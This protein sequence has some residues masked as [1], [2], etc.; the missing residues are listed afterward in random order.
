MRRSERRDI[1]EGSLLWAAA[2]AAALFAAGFR[3]RRFSTASAVQ[4]SPL[5]EQDRGRLA[6]AP[7]KIPTRGWKDILLRAFHNISEHR[8]M[9]L[10]AGVTFY[11]LLAL[12][13]AIAALVAIYG[14]FAD[15]ATLS[16]DLDK[17]S[18]VLPGGAIEVIHDQLARLVAQ[19]GSTLGLTFIV[20]LAI[21]LWSANA[22]MKSLFGTL[23]VVYAEPEKRGLVTLN[24]Q[25][26]A[27]TVGGIVF[28]VVALGAM[29][30]L[31][32]LLGFLGLSGFTETLLR[33]GR[34]PALFV[35][36]MLAL[37][38]IYRHGP[39]REQAQW[40]WVT[41][42]SAFAALAW[43]VLSILFSWYAEN[44]GSFN[45]TYGSLGAVIGFMTWIWLSA[46]VILIGAELDAEMEHQT[47]RDTTTGPPM[48]LGARQAT[49]ADTIGAR[50]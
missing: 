30:V 13:P 20:S 14:L 5:R 49:M 1:V 24:A 45:R 7:A 9:D 37:A 10:A 44:F 36:L 39:S 34:W 18:G 22:A 47:A 40:R 25:S 50:Q 42:G 43:L 28:I 16:A 26:L 35:V 23:N 21:S 12:F 17:M 33:V 19:R 48:P 32:P 3:P 27:F 2:I 8:I 11:S 4:S 38:I 46:I 15:P 6:E 31:P 41:W 29:V